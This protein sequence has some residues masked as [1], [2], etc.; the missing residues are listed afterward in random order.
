MTV[1]RR[2]WTGGKQ[3]SEGG[4]REWTRQGDWVVEGL[5]PATRM[6][7]IR[8]TLR[9]KSNIN[10]SYPLRLRIK[11]KDHPVTM[12]SYLSPLSGTFVFVALNQQQR[13]WQW[14]DD[15]HGGDGN[16]DG[17]GGVVAVKGGGGWM[18]HRP[19]R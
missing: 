9:N 1:R 12:S 6:T 15:E 19:Q 3:H 11:G 8:H 4:G 7:L 13:H 17:D 14:G 2:G 16:G 18:C 5:V 10:P